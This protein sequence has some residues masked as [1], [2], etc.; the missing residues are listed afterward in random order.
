MFILIQVAAEAMKLGPCSHPQAIPPSS[1]HPNSGQHRFYYSFSLIFE[2]KVA[3]S[4]HRLQPM[5]LD[6][7]EES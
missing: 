5:M 3:K 1:T 2:K 4:P 6:D 7:D